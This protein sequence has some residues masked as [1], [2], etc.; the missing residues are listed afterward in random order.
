MELLVAYCD[1]AGVFGKKVELIFVLVV[2]EKSNKLLSSCTL[3]SLQ[4]RPDKFKFLHVLKAETKLWEVIFP[5]LHK[6]D[7]GDQICPAEHFCQT[8]PVRLSFTVP[9][10]KSEKLRIGIVPPDTQRTNI[11][12][13]DLF[14]ELFDP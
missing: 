11:F 5:A 12:L 2:E 9:L 6:G 8:K 13:D 4:V 7:V 1:T 3:G 14:A 10:L